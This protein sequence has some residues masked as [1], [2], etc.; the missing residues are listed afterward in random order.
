MALCE[1]SQNHFVIFKKERNR[2]IVIDSS[3]GKYNTTIPEFLK[4]F[5]GIIIFIKKNQNDFD[6]KDNKIKLFKHINA[7]YIAI[8]IFL[9]AAL[10][11]FSIIGSLYLTKYF[12]NMRLDN[13]LTTSIWICIFFLFIFFIEQLI[14]YL[15]QIIIFEQTKKNCLSLSNEILNNTN[16]DSDFFNKVD[17]K[18]YCI[19]NDIIKSIA[20]FNSLTII[21]FVA[22]C[23][24]NLTILVIFSFLNVFY[25]LLG[26]ISL[27]TF[28]IVEFFKYKFD[29]KIQYKMLS[30][31][32][33]SFENGNDIAKYISSNRNIYKYHKIASD[34]KSN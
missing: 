12:I 4:F 24:S 19:V 26:F 11:L 13:S 29:S 7:R 10:L 25:V 22:V 27:A 33:N 30:C 28:L 2:V 21:N 1:N 15:C 8:N 5:S 16:K 3:R 14:K 6:I 34:F 17:K 20:S 18:Y 31:S 23:I 32:V 9:Q